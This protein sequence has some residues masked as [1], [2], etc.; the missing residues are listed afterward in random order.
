MK[1][2]FKLLKETVSEWKED[3]ASR[4]AAALSYYTIFSLAPL[5]LVTITVV[6]FVM[7][8]GDVKGELYAKIRDLVG[9]DGAGMIE[10]MVDNAAASDAKGIAAVVSVVTLLLGAAGVFNALKDALNTIWN[11]QPAPGRGLVGT[12]KDRLLSFSLIPAIG[13]LL[14]V[15]LI[16]DAVL[17]ALSNS[18]SGMFLSDVWVQT[19]RVVS[20]AVSFGVITVL[21]AI[22]YK[23]LPD[24]QVAWRD[25]WIG[26]AVTSLLFTLG[27]FAI[28]LYIGNSSTAS[29]F[30]AA[31]SLIV[32]LLWIYYAAQLLFFGA[33][34]T[35]VYARR[36]G[37]KI[38]PEAGAE[39][40]TDAARAE[41]GLSPRR[42]SA[43]RPAD[44]N[45]PIAAATYV[46]KGKPLGYALT[47]LIAFFLG[48][49]VN[50]GG[51]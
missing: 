16:V 28:G 5:L 31:G 24:A 30:G 45:P 37:S 42:R 3:K 25:V 2:V 4:L 6:G 39:P 14:L 9:E 34:F 23:V 20:L 15:S 7:E 29:A 38:V 21:F 33:E 40:L 32:I 11:V 26:A 51:D 10:T 22:V 41:Q 12:L 50:R 8:P 17:S 46:Q 18:M 44:G 49:L 13:F 35:Q 48:V 27:R 1:T 43:P 19:I 47:G 36:Y